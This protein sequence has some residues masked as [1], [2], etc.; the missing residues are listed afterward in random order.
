VTNIHKEIQSIISNLAVN[1][2]KRSYDAY[3]DPSGKL[4][5][6]LQQLKSI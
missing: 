5:E 6:G 2:S 4:M 1:T 3:N